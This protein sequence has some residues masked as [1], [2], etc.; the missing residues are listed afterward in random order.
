MKIDNTKE[1]STTM[2][3]LEKLNEIRHTIKVDKQLNAKQGYKAFTIAKLNAELNPLLRKYKIGILCKVADQQVTP[4]DK[5]SQYGAKTN[6]LVTGSAEYTLVD[7]ET[8]DREIVSIPY[9]GMNQ[10]G[11][12]SKSMGNASS[13]AYKYLWITL[14]GLT[15][16]T[17]DV[18]SSFYDDQEPQESPLEGGLQEEVKNSSGSFKDR[19]ESK[20]IYHAYVAKL[21]E[22]NGAE[23]TQINRDKLA[24]IL[25]ELKQDWDKIFNYEKQKLKLLKDQVIKDWELN[26]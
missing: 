15:D 25:N 10:A 21:E 11:D 24:N 20:A 5:E 2:K 23:P 16:E 19:G 18:D 13:Y 9:I 17:S 26:I 12:P 14:L 1:G 3:L 22:F 7:L 8:N 4:I 6:F